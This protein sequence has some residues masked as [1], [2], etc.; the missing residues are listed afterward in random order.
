V[1]SPAGRARETAALVSSVLGAPPVRVD[2]R[3]RPLDLGQGTDGKPLSWDQRIAEWE[4]G[5]DPAPPGGESLEQ[6]GARVRDVVNELAKAR[7]GEQ[8]VLVAHGEVIGSFLGLVAGTPPAKR[9]PPD[10]RNGSVTVVD[11]SEGRLKVL[12]SNYV[13]PESGPAKP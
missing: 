9:Y 13:A 4:G 10:L 2:R 8:I 12:L 11:V 6:V 7:A 3:L 5:R 1:S